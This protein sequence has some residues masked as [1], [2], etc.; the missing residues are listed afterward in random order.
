MVASIT[1]IQPI[2]NFLIHQIL[3]N[4]VVAKWYTRPVESLPAKTFF[5]LFFLMGWDCVHLVLRPLF[6]LLYQPQMTE[7][8]CRANGGMRNGR[9]NRSTSRKPVTEEPLCPPPIP[10]DVAWARTRATAV[11]SRR[12]TACA[13][14]RPQSN[15]WGSWTIARVLKVR[16]TWSGMQYSTWLRSSSWRHYE[17]LP[18]NCNLLHT[19]PS[20]CYMPRLQVMTY[21]ITQLSVFTSLIHLNGF[22]LRVIS[23][24][25]FLLA[26]QS[27]SVK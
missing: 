10:H 12:L 25:L 19:K 9:E 11:G 21:C 27:W 16:S 15:T 17:L 22:S 4:T 6:D 18:R 23:D 26:R 20:L 14:A 2:L 5:P 24:I 8:N 13:M 7:D 1:R 3:I